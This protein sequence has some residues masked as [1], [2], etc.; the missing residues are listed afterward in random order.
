MKNKTKLKFS[1]PLAVAILIGTVA[2]FGSVAAYQSYSTDSP[3]VVVEGNYIESATG[4]QVPVEKALGSVTSPDI[5]STWIAVNGDIQYHIVAPLSKTTSTLVSFV[6]PFGTSTFSSVE[7][8]RLDF[9]TAAS[10]SLTA[11]STVTCGAAATPTSAVSTAI[12]TSDAFGVSTTPFIANAITTALGAT[13][14]GGTT[15]KIVL[16]PTYPYFVCTASNTSIFGTSAV[17]GSA[18]VRVSKT[19]F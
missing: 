14:G 4:T 2:V 5:M 3:K 8:A 18:T 10:S 16:S 13:I 19:R 1:A 9:T 7:M 12:L 6:N 11:T 17:G 15:N